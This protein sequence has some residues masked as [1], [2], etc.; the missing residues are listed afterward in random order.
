MNIPCKYPNNFTGLLQIVEYLRGPNG[1]PWDREQTSSSVKSNILEECYELLEAI[2]QNDIR[3][4]IEELGDLIFHIAFQINIGKEEGTF[5][6][7]QVFGK[8]NDKLTRRHPHVFENVENLDS[9]D[10]ELRWHKIKRKERGGE[11]TS[12][13]DGIPEEL[14]ALLRAQTIQQRASHAGFDWNKLKGVIDKIKEELDEL[15]SARS[16]EELES[17]LGDTLFSIVNLARWIDTDA[18]GALR[19]TN[20]RF[21]KRFSMMEDICKKRG[22]LFENLTMPDKENLWEEA[23]TLVG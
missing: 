6:D 15:Q 7:E 21:K 5:S 2:D 16:Q 13:L 10:I 12:A 9:P 20:V 1:C 11:K 18:E 17:E 14:P 8:I 4:K 23:K 19:K 22:V 3:K